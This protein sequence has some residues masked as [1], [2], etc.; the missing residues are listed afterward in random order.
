MREI[1]EVKMRAEKDR[2]TMPKTEETSTGILCPV[3]IYGDWRS[4][5]FWASVPD[6]E[7][8]KYMDVR[9]LTEDQM[10]AVKKR[11]RVVMIKRLMEMK[12]AM[13]RSLGLREW[14]GEFDESHRKD[15]GASIHGS[16]DSYQQIHNREL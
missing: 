15:G 6:V 1:Q 16:S 9:F 10:W 3:E 11:D 13:Q 2:N 7:P 4:R 5:P 12:C 14:W 8:S